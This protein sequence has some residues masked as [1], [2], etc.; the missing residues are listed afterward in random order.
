MAV[1]RIKRVDVKAALQG[2]KNGQ[3]IDLRRQ[4]SRRDERPAN[5]FRVVHEILTSQKAVPIERQSAGRLDSRPMCQPEALAA[6]VQ[7][8][9][10]SRT[11]AAGHDLY[12]QR[13]MSF[14]QGADFFAK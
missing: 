10:A 5:R 8:F 11:Q 13:W 3:Q 7:L 9:G 1:G 6:V 12:S 14:H 2:A 4:G